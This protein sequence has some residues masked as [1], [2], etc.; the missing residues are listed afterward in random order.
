MRPSHGFAAISSS[1]S[2]TRSFATSP[3]SA[4][5]AQGAGPASAF[6]ALPRRDDRSDGP[7]FEALAHHWREAGESEKAIDSPH[8]GG[9]SG[10]PRLGKE[11]AITLYAQA[12]ELM[13]EDDA[14]QA[15][16]RLRQVVTAQALRTTSSRTTSTS[17]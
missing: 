5:P 15:V 11:H 13:P 16:V 1:P 8:H 2:S 6:A 12:L 4:S 14:E 7:V 10:G 3:T 9:G 17:E